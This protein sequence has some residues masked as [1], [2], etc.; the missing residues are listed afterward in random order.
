[1]LQ[2]KYPVSDAVTMERRSRQKKME[3]AYGGA[4]KPDILESFKLHYEE[5]GGAIINGKLITVLRRKLHGRH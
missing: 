5:L 4:R 2:W 3:V 1:M